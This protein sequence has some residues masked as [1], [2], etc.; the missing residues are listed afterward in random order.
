[1]GSSIAVH[2]NTIVDLSTGFGWLPL[3][4][5]AGLTYNFVVSQLAQDGQ[6]AGY[7]I[8]TRMQVDQLF[9]DFGL[10]ITHTP[11]VISNA[12]NPLGDNAATPASPIAIDKFISLFGQTDCLS[13]CAGAA[14]AF[15]MFGPLGYNGTAD[16]LLVVGPGPGR[17]RM[18]P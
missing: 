4:D 16:N 14:G 7:V 18:G 12:D 17:P 3:T 9:A 2:A 15:G 10:P 6:F 5:T 8:A 1:L 13:P 11:Q